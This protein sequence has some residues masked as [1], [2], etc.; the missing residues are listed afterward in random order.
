VF[1][2]ESQAEVSIKQELRE[3]AKGEAIASFY[4]HVTTP[5]VTE[6]VTPEVID[7]DPASD[8][9]IAELCR[10]CN[11]PLPPSSKLRREHN[12]SIAHLARVVDDRPNPLK[13]LPIDQSSFGYKV[14]SSQGWDHK[15]RHGIGAADNKGRREPVKASRVK[16][17]TVGLGIKADKIKKAV[18]EKKLLESGK[19]IRER[20]EKEKQIRKELMDYMQH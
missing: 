7:L 3:S 16:N 9:E 2:R 8:S 19:E 6:T 4:R 17:D 10:V 15:D 1:Q 14:L 13:P 12:H 5:P 20:Y 18:E 11:L